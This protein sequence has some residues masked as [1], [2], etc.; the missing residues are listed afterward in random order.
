MRSDFVLVDRQSLF[1]ESG[2]PFSILVVVEGLKAG[3]ATD[4]ELSAAVFELSLGLFLLIE[5]P[6]CPLVFGF[7]L[8]PV[9]GAGDS[10]HFLGVLLGIVEL[11]TDLYSLL[12]YVHSIT[13][14]IMRSNRY[15]TSFKIFQM[16]PFSYSGL[17]CYS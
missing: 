11:L 13:Y 15:N 10:L 5:Q 16:D 9:S 3:C 14:S 1:S 12:D 4:Y 6:A 2:F 17:S 7:G 8:E